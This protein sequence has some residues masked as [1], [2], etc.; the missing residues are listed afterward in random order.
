MQR[1]R[2]L[3]RLGASEA[4]QNPFLGVVQHVADGALAKKEP[5]RDRA[6]PPTLIAQ[7]LNLVALYLGNCGARASSERAEAA[8]LPAT[9]PA[10]SCQARQRAGEPPVSEQ[11]MLPSVAAPTTSRT[12]PISPRNI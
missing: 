12:K 3:S 5:G 2:V 10:L 8:T 1:G 9:E 7:L 11:A 6:S 4:G